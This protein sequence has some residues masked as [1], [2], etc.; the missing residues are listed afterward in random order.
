MT[1]KCE[2]DAPAANLAD[3]VAAS[4]QSVTKL[5]RTVEVVA[6]GSLPKDGKVIERP[7]AW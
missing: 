3:A 6:A 4:L 2:A 1:L 5:R 7:R